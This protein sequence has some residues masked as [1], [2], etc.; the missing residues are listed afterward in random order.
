MK[1][2]LLV[3]GGFL[4]LFLAYRYYNKKNSNMLEV[5]KKEKPKVDALDELESKLKSSELTMKDIPNLKKDNPKLLRV[6]WGYKTPIIRSVIN[7]VY[8]YLLRLIV[9]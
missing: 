6:K 2:G 3:G 5:K 1:K 8:F 9:S 7:G 4:A